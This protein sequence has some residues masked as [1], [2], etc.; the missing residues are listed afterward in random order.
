[1]FATDRPAWSLAIGAPLG[2]AVVGG[3]LT[4]D[5]LTTWY[6]TLRK[7]RLVL[8]VWAF[9]PVAVLYYLMCGTI[10]F[11]LV[12][13][14][15]PSREQRTALGLLLSMMTANE[16]WNYLLFGRRSTQAGLLGMLAFVGVAV[17]LFRALQRVDPQSATLL[18][19][20]LGWL[21]YDIVYAYEIWR[22]NH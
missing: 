11:R 19:P 9:I 13:R 21:G 6:P 8:P 12:A 16:G 20:Y 14:V 10:L 1:V 17:S 22:L 18:L 2:F 7:S 3:A 4:G 5:A 15:A